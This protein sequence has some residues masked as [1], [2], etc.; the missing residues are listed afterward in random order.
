VKPATDKRPNPRLIGLS[1]AG[2][3]AL[4]KNKLD[5]A[6]SYFDQMLAID[7]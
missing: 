6:A 7:P 4:E 3:R 5:E 2:Y 1:R